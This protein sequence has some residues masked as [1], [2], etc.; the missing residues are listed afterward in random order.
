MWGYVFLCFVK[1]S[2]QEKLKHFNKCLPMFVDKDTEF[3]A[4]NP[5]LCLTQT[6]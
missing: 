4:S 5:H 6:Q 2:P 1:I 3:I